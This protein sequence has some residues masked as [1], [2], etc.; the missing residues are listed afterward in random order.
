MP[1]WELALRA[2]KR[3]SWWIQQ[4]SGVSRPQMSF[5]SS[6]SVGIMSTY[7]DV[8]RGRWRWRG[9]EQDPKVE[10]LRGRAQPEPAAGGGDR[11]GVRRL[12]VLRR[13]GPGAGQVRDGAPGAGRRAAGERGRRR[14]SG[15]PA[16]R[17]IRPPPRWTPAGWPALVP[18]RPGPRRAHK[19]TEEV[20]DVRPPAARRATRRCARR[21]LVDAIAERF[22]VRV[23]PRSVERALARAERAQKRSRP[24]STGGRRPRRRSSSATSSCARRALAGDPAGWRLGLAVLQRRG[25]AAWMR[26]WRSAD[27][28]PRAEPPRPSDRA[29]AGAPAGAAERAGRRAR[30]DGAGLSAAGR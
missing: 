5:D 19:L 29:L 1:G 28:P 2:E 20:V 13:P 16:R 9:D 24:M 18:A 6:D 4:L 30:R 7:I 15:S 11:R 12:G 23:H 3:A 25:V 21:E 27:P 22:G 10:A 8:I 26:A 17:S 14:R